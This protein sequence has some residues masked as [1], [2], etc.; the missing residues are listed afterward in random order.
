LAISPEPFSRTAPIHITSLSEITRASPDDSKVALIFALSKRPGKMSLRR[1]RLPAPRVAQAV[2]K[3]LTWP[4][5]LAFHR[6]PP[7]GCT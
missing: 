3:D 5:S 7:L 6:T 1:K 2:A 4:F